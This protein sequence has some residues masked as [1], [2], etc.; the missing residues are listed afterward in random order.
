MYPDN[1]IFAVE[2]EFRTTCVPGL[3]ERD[4]IEEI[5][6][7]IKGAK[8]YY[9]QQ[10]RTGEPTLVPSYMEIV[11]YSK[12][13]LEEFLDIARMYIKVAGIRGI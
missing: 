2:Y 8:R 13:K 12:E 4:D 3:V 9:L 11:P 10:F 7:L 6:R 5:S 1:F